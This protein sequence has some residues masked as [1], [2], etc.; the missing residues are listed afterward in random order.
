M[1]EGAKDFVRKKK[2]SEDLLQQ[3]EPKET[4]VKSTRFYVIGSAQPR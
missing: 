3:Q 2:E 1:I 4:Q